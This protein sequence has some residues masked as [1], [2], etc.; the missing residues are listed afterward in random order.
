MAGDRQLGLRALRLDSW[1]CPLEPWCQAFVATSLGMARA[2]RALAL[3]HGGCF[4]GQGDMT[5]YWFSFLIRLVKLKFQAGG[6]KTCFIM[7]SVLLQLIVFH[8]R[9]CSSHEDMRPVKL[10]AKLDCKGWTGAFRSKD[11]T[12]IPLKSRQARFM[13][14]S[15]ICSPSLTVF[16]NPEN[17]LSADANL[18]KVDGRLVVI[19]SLI[20]KHNMKPHWRILQSMFLHVFFSSSCFSQSLVFKEHRNIQTKCSWSKA[21]RKT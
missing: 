20:P 17:R 10:K 9:W 8:R 4:L 3:G 12:G 19:C 18:E 1:L 5:G 21:H 15:N 14:T 13:Q 11:L 2:E 7:F 16:L 6:N